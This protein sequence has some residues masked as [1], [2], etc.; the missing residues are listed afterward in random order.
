MG[1]DA[2]TTKQHS[3]GTD[4]HPLELDE[5]QIQVRD[6]LRFEDTEQYPFSEWYLSALYTLNNTSTPDRIAQAAHSLRELLEKLLQTIQGQDEEKS[7]RDRLIGMRDKM[8]SALSK[9]KRKNN[10]SLGQEVDKHLI[11]TVNLLDKY[12]KENKNPFGGKI[13]AAAVSI[14]HRY[15]T[16][17]HKATVDCLHDDIKKKLLSIAHHNSNISDGKFRGLVKELGTMILEIILAPVIEEKRQEIQEILGKHDRSDSDVGHLLLL[18]IARKELYTFFFKE[19][20]NSADPFWL[21]HL[22][23]NGHFAKPPKAKIDKDVNIKKEKWPPIKYLVVLA[24]NKPDARKK[25]AEVVSKLPV[26]SNPEI[27][28]RLIE[29]SNYLPD[30]EYKQLKSKILAYKNEVYD[31]TGDDANQFT[32]WAAEKKVEAALK[33]LPSLVRFVPDEFDEEKRS[34]FKEEHDSKNE[35]Q[36]DLHATLDTKLEPTAPSDSYHYRKLLSEGVRK[37]IEKEPYKTALILIEATAEMLHL[38]THDGEDNFSS[39][40]CSSL[41][42]EDG[43]YEDDQNL[44][45]HTLTSACETVYEKDVSNIDNLNKKLRDQTEWYLLHTR[46]RIHLYRKY[47]SDVTKTWIREMIVKYDWHEQM[48]ID[49]DFWCMIEAACNELGEKLLSIEERTKVFE[50]IR[51]EPSQDDFR[52]FN[53]GQDFSDEE[54]QRYRV[55]LPRSRFFPFEKVLF[56]DYKLLFE[57]LKAMPIDKPDDIICF[58]PPDTDRRSHFD[59]SPFSLKELIIMSDNELLA[60]VNTWDSNSSV[61]KNGNILRI[62]KIGLAAMCYSLFKSSVVSNQNRFKFWLDNCSKVKHPIYLQEMICAMREL[63]KQGNHDMI[64]NY[65]AFNKLALLRSDNDRSNDH[66]ILQA[67]DGHGW[68]SVRWAICSFVGV[69]LQND[70]GVLPNIWKGLLDILNLFFTQYDLA[71]DNEGS[72]KYMMKDHFNEGMNT[73]RGRALSMLIKLATA[74]KQQDDEI[75][76][77]AIINVIEQRLSPQAKLPLTPYEHAILGAKYLLISNYD[78]GWAYRHRVTI[79]PQDKLPSWLAAFAA[80]I[81]YNHPCETMFEVV[82]DNLNFALQHV[83]ALR[84]KHP[85]ETKTPLIMLEKRLFSFYFLGFYPLKEENSLLEQYYKKVKFDAN[86]RENL[87]RAV[88]VSLRD[89]GGQINSKQREKFIAFFMW[90]L[91]AGSFAKMVDLTPWLNSKYLKAEEQLDA[92]YKALTSPNCKTD[93]YS[94][95]N[96]LEIFSKIPPDHTKK[97]VDCLVELVKQVK[98]SQIAYVDKESVRKIYAALNSNDAHVSDRAQRACDWLLRYDSND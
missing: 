71:L 25:V 45:V 55:A 18:I 26:A 92:C 2:S 65:L 28:N 13:L 47:P 37:L 1:D 8:E 63:V 78:K 76:F 3:S 11:D 29:I 72:K 15:N 50:A 95:N 60:L 23:K 97:I 5:H 91:N 51:K 75:A 70:K 80:L 21:K 33:V 19:I 34:R 64:G 68:L 98:K 57:K 82:K 16:V 31:L 20:I 69:C 83:D 81:G 62:S 46:M 54:F 30:N 73:V 35:G 84:G 44:L 27:L 24:K 53:F 58:S 6:A 38:Q 14:K 67:R 10:G 94:V 48:P 32:Q 7:D 22:I 93:T 49:T 42:H 86:S 43:E 87:L 4:E 85:Y 89:E 74:V 40:W 52:K 96:W 66:G 59:R 56:D 61:N 90:Q 36:I 17:A 77:S 41:Q 88:G 12:I 79:F 39:V 9:H